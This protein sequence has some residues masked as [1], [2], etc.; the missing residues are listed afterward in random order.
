MSRPA[1]PGAS[2]PPHRPIPSTTTDPDPDFRVVEEEHPD[3]S[4][5]G[6]PFPVPVSAPLDFSQGGDIVIEDDGDGSG[7]I[8]IYGPFQGSGIVIEDDD[9]TSGGY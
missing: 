7:S 3:S 9:L 2:P 6:V 8:V 1:R 4:W 5:R